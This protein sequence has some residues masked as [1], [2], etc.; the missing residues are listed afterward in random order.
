[1]VEVPGDDL[2]FIAVGLH[3]DRV[4]KNQQPVVRLDGADGW[5][6][7]RP[8]FARGRVGPRQKAGDQVMALEAQSVQSVMICSRYASL[9]S[10]AV[11]ATWSFSLMLV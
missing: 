1:M 4:V 11:V 3:L 6:D 9:T 10:S 2:V 8:E 5:L 7:Q